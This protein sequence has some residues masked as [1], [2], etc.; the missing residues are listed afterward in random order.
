M[1][2]HHVVWQMVK[3][4]APIFKADGGNIFFKKLALI[5]KTTK[6]QVHNLEILTVMSTSQSTGITSAFAKVYTNVTQTTDDFQVSI[7][8]T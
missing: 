8:C 6:P 5:Y 2:R 1:T 4:A 3:S 7:F